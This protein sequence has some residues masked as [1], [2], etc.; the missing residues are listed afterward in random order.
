MPAVKSGDWGSAAWELRSVNQ[1]YLETYFRLP[2]Q[3][4]SLEPWYASAF[5]PA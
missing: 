5:A 3:F 4:R 1:R 2:E